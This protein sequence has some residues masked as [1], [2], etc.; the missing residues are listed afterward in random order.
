M[1]RPSRR[2]GKRDLDA[3]RAL[4]E[5]GTNKTLADAGQ[6]GLYAQGRDHRVRFLFRYTP[7]GGGPRRTVSLDSYG[8]ITL[9]Q[10]RAAAQKL[11]GQLVEGVDPAA[12]RAAEAVAAA[13]VAEVVAA[14]VADRA[15]RRGKGGAE[16]LRLLTRHVLPALGRVAIRDVTADRVRRLHR[17]MRD[18]PIEANR[19]LS[20][21]AAVF[22]WAE[23]AERVPADFSNPC[24]HVERYEEKGERRALSVEE[25]G[26]LGEAMRAAEASTHPSALLA[27]RLLALTGMRRSEVLGLRWSSVDL[28]RGLVRLAATKTGAQTRAIG[29]AAIEQLRRARPAEAAPGDCVCPGTRSGRA[30]VGIDKIRKRLWDAAGISANE[31]GRADLHSL[32]HSFASVGVH[33]AGG[34][35]AGHVSPLLGHGHQARAITERYITANPEAL[36]PAADAISEELARILGLG[37]PAD[38]LQFPKR[39]E[40]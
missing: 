9:D 26:R 14:Y 22:A 12:A 38:L 15:L 5:A 11:R 25:L 29:A 19:T 30:F 31:N 24:R 36:R 21:L 13:T 35:W 4:A 10:A 7:P 8:A 16:A 40:R 37:M 6:P 18:T 3:L 17:A 34:R 39:S 27:I 1:P 20:A 32:R 33:A 23:R 2:L 28:D